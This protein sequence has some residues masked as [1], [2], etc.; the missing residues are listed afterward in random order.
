MAL[1]I[2]DICK[3]NILS[4]SALKVIYGLSGRVG[5]PER[6]GPNERF[7]AHLQNPQKAADDR[8]LAVGN[9]TLRHEDD[10]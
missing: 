4:D 6:G 7:R 9:T 5:A 10:F 2:I 1:R 3:N 8:F